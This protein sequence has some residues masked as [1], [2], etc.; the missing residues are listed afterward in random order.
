M[1]SKV[2]DCSPISQSV[3]EKEE[4]FYIFKFSPTPP[5]VILEVLEVVVRVEFGWWWVG[6]LTHGKYKG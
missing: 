6:W 1:L 3:P 4:M 5:P 2:V